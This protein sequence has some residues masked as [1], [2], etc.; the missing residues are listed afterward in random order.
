MK[1][2]GEVPSQL[3]KPSSL[4]VYVT[5]LRSQNSSE[6]RSQDMHLLLESLLFPLLSST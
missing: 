4:S 3:R 2:V 5:N 1:L 6:W